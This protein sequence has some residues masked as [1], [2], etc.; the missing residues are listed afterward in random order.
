MVTIF[1]LLAMLIP[2]PCAAAL[3]AAFCALGNTNLGNLCLAIMGCYIGLS[4]VYTGAM[5]GHL[6]GNFGGNSG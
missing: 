4:W 1:F 3:G 2:Q 5:Y 6:Y